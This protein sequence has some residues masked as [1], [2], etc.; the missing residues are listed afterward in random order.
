MESKTDLPGK[1][2][3]CSSTSFLERCEVK[4]NGVYFQ[5]MFCLK[6]GLSGWW[7]VAVF[8]LYISGQ[9]V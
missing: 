6:R 3:K 4:I 5:D 8:L 7:S 2:R 1:T 9:S